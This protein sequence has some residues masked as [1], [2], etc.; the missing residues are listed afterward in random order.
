MPNFQISIIFRTNI[1]W[2]RIHH[3]AA[4]IIIV[5]IC[6]CRNCQHLNNNIYI[7]LILSFL[8]CS[9]YRYRPFRSFTLSFID[10]FLCFIYFL[11][12]LIASFLYCSFYSY[13]SSFCFLIRI[14]KQEIFIQKIWLV[15]IFILPAVQQ[16]IPIVTD[17]PQGQKMICRT[18]MVFKW[19]S[20][21]ELF[22]SYDDI[23]WIFIVLPNTTFILRQYQILINIFYFSKFKIAWF[24]DS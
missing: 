9:F 8:Y 15:P 19:P 12:S 4:L 1:Y 2:F 11:F 24:F 17:Y 3:T 20:A 16:R 14:M 22:Q 7:Y 10:L 6:F 21:L 18:P 23:L 13:K 5:T